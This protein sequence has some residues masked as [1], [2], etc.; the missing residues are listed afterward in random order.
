M[1]LEVR[2]GDSTVEDI[3][4]TIK[5]STAE[6]TTVRGIQQRGLVE[7]RDIS[8]WADKEEVNE[9]LN[10]AGIAE[11]RLVNL[12]KTFGGPQAA[13]VVVPLQAVRELLGVGRLR[14][15][16]VNCRVRLCEKNERCFRYTNKG[17]ESR[18]CNGPDRSKCCRR[19]GGEGNFAAK[20]LADSQAAK[21]FRQQLE[22][23]TVRAETQA[24]NGGE[25]N[26]Q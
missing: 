21:L 16:L 14:I 24:W 18:D 5:E 22:H 3:K 26:L 6:G 17:H 2:G 15:G 4:K 19:C 13:T 25:G 20:C 23:E 9:A 7:I 12:R 8:C 11:A 10:R 1:L